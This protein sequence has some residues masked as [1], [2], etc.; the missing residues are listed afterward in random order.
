MAGAVAYAMALFGNPEASIML[1]LGI[2]GHATL[3]VGSICLGQKI[4]DAETERSFYPPLV[5]SSPCNTADIITHPKAHTT[6]RDNA[7]RDMEATGFYEMAVKFSCGELIQVIKIISD[8]ADS[9]IEK[10]NESAVESW[11][12]AKIAIVEKVLNELTHLRQ[13]LISP[14]CTSPLFQT[15]TAKFHFTSANATKLKALLQRWLLVKGNE[16]D[17]SH[18]N[19]SSAR[20]LLKWIEQELDESALWL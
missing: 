13:S 15:L 10:I 1:N 6:Y 12:D 3:E 5:F 11:I 19:I 4:S 17:Y 20:E 8:N 18:T 14:D 2:G 7:I 9:P 16:L